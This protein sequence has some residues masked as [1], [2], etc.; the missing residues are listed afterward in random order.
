MNLDDRYLIWKPVESKRAYS[1]SRFDDAFLKRAPDSLVGVWPDDAFCVVD[2][3]RHMR[4]AFV[5]DS[6]LNA[7]KRL[8]VSSR[9]K[10]A[11]VRAS[12]TDVEYWPIKVIDRTGRPMSEPY[13]FVHL[14]NLPDCLDL[15]ASGATRSRMRTS[16][17]EKIERFEFKTD[18]ERPLLRP[19]PLASV[20]LVRWPLAETLAKEGFRGFRFMGLFDYGIKGDLPANP[21]RAPVDVLCAQLLS[22]V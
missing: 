12:V 22:V 15:D 8:I 2:L 21:K 4:D 17:A 19:K 16:I 3:E 10:A 14:M 18:P 5:P 7:G 11:L 9:L 6:L 1:I 13:F 20:V